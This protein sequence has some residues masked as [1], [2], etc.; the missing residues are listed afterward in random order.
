MKQNKGSV[1]R[2][3]FC[4]VCVSAQTLIC[5]KLPESPALITMPVFARLLQE[6]IAIGTGGDCY[7]HFPSVRDLLQHQA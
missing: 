4:S 3:P 2:Q 6:T 7:L 1:G 5:C